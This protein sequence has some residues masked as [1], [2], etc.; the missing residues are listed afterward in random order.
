MER[1]AEVSSETAVLESY[2]RIEQ[3]KKRCLGGRLE[4]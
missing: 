1:L 4:T 2:R 3:V